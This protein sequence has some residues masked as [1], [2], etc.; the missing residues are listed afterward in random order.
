MTITMFVVHR[1]NNNVIAINV[2]I[3]HY[4][5]SEYSAIMLDHQKWNE[6]KIFLNFPHTMLL[7]AN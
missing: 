4:D 6:F 1:N 3:S 7:T 2:L 5:V